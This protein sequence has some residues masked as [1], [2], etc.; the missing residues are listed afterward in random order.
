MVH[1]KHAVGARGETIAT[2]FLLARGCDLVAS[3]A[4]ADGG[5]VDLVIRDGYRVAAVEVKLATDGADPLEA[6]DDRKFALVTRTVAGL[7]LWIDRIDLLG[8]SMDAEGCGIR[9]LRGV[10]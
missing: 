9:W 6:V 5:E 2:A 8:V 1:D 4:R 7:D 3:N 10:D